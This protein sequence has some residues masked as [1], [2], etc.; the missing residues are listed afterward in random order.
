MAKRVTNFSKNE[1]TLLLDLVLKYKDILECK[2]T[3]T[4]NNKIKWEVWMQLTKEF[5]SVS[6]ETTRDVK[7]LKNKYENIKKRTKQKFAGIKKYASGTGG[8]PPQNPVFTNT[9]E[10]LHEI[11][12]P[13]ITGTQSSYDYDSKERAM[14]G[15]ATFKSLDSLSNFLPSTSERKMPGPSTSKGLD[16]LTN[17]LPSTSERTMTGPSTSKGLQ[18]PSTAR[19]TEMQEAKGLNREEDLLSW[20]NEIEEISFLV[21]SSDED[22][23]NN[24]DMNEEY[25]IIDEPIKNENRQQNDPESLIGQEDWSTYT[26]K[27]LKQKKAEP[28][29]LGTKKNLKNTV[30]KWGQAKEGHIRQQNSCLKAQHERK[31]LIMGIVA[32]KKITMMEEEAARNKLE[33]EKR[34]ELMEKTMAL[35]EQEA[36]ERKE[37]MKKYLKK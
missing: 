3:D 28:L 6:G 21:G 36:E 37:I 16:R 24:E 27:M 25:I 18:K 2:K 32:K 12:G 7:G 19:E 15:H 33:H 5:N 20:T 22:I 1:E 9:D 34:M 26:P 35:I 29:R 11:I 10:A 8:G 23:F 13:Q 31:M 14:P 4:S 30:A 17:F